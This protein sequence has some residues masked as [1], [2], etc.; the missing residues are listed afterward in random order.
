MEN[1]RLSVFGANFWDLWLQKV[2]RNFAS[3]KFQW[4]TVL[5]LTTV[6]A[7][8]TTDRLGDAWISAELGFGF[9]GGGFVT[10]CT[11]RIIANTRLTEPKGDGMD[12]DR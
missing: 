9:L 2:F 7:M 5:Y 11:A 10:F 8:F 3:V 1:D 6:F 12:T 4:M